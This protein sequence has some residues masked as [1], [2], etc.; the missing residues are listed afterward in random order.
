MA[1]DNVLT[2]WMRM[3][4]HNIV[5]VNPQRNKYQTPKTIRPTLL[6]RSSNSLKESHK[7]NHND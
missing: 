3:P 2:D 6:A 7:L 1:K 5:F 4:Q